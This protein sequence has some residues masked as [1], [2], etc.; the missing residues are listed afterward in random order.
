MTTDRKD[1]TREAE[2]ETVAEVIANET[3]SRWSYVAAEKVIAALDAVSSGSA[4]QNQEERRS[5]CGGDPSQP[6][7][8]GCPQVAVERSPRDEDHA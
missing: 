2:I 5:C 8:A 6:H 1:D 7:I 3:G 4:A